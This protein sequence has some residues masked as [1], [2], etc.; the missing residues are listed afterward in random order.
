MEAFTTEGFEIDPHLIK[1]TERI[2]KN[3]FIPQLRRIYSSLISRIDHC[4]CLLMGV[5]NQ[6]W[7]SSGLLGQISAREIERN[8]PDFVNIHW[9]GHAT[10]SLRQILKIQR[11]LI[12]TAHDQWW[13]NAVSHYSNS[14]EV[15]QAN[16]F[17]RLLTK[18]LLDAKN[19]ILKKSNTGVVCLSREMKGEFVARY[20]FLESRIIVIPNPVDS[21]V[22]S[23][24]PPKKNSQAIP[25][26]IYLGGFTDK[27]KGYDLLLEALKKCEERF[28]LVATG[29]TGDAITGKFGQV[30]IVG[31][32]K[33]RDETS[34][35]KLFNQA[36]LT[37][38]PSR[39]EALPQVA[40]ESL[41]VGTPVVSFSVGGLADIVLDGITG[42]KVPPFDTSELAKAIDFSIKNDSK[43][44]LSAREF[45]LSKFSRK[46]IVLDYVSFSKRLLE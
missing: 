33:I 4:L 24:L 29:F 32:P 21:D 38:V 8:S 34:M 36:D 23:P 40:T 42:M 11:P 25:K 2:N 16:F 7:T 43:K 22:F 35:N 31:I 5:N 10:L 13:L 19:E 28:D 9:I 17:A 1:A 15:K 46:K 26:L 39:Q 12:I 30:C 14:R 37:V 20:P 3:T 45:A 6:H 44:H 27:R 41:M 18:R